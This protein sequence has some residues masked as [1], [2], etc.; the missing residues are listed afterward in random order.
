MHRD[1]K[2]EN[3][4]IDDK[5][6]LKVIDFG[7]SMLVSDYGC[8]SDTAGT[9][10]YMA[11]EVFYRKSDKRADWWAVGIIIYE[12]LIGSTP[13]FRRDKNAIQQAIKKDCAVFPR[14]RDFPTSSAFRN[15]VS[16]LLKKDPNERLS[17][18]ADIF[19]HEFFNG[20]DPESY[21][22]AP[23]IPLTDPRRSATSNERFYPI[24]DKCQ[25]TVSNSSK[26]LI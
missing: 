19:A 23:Y 25:S 7:L 2:P 3:I 16:K 10:P 20:V 22:K 24:F 15:L 18:A 11:P 21:P 9:L 5:G 1:L 4:V 17:C 12:M 8:I 13:F 6:D 26:K 14:E